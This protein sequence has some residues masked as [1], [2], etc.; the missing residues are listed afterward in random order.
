MSTARRWLAVGLA[1]GA[2]AL[3]LGLWLRAPAATVA[4]QLVRL[5][6]FFLHLQALA[7]A[8]TTVWVWSALRR[9]LG[10]GRRTLQALVAASAL[11]AGFTVAVAP[12]TNRI[13]YDEQIYQ[14]V[15]QSLA[16]RGRAEVCLEGS[17]E[18]GRLD[19]IRGQYNKQPYGYPYLVSWAFRL[20]GTHE[21]LA[22]VVNN[23]C[24]AALP[25][26]VWAL[27]SLLFD[28]AAA[29]W[30]AL[31]AALVPLVAVWSN[32]TAAEPSAMLF[33][34]LA[35]TAAT[36]Y[37]RHPGR[38]TLAWAVAALAFGVQFRPESAFLLPLALAFIVLLAPA[39]ARRAR[40]WLAGAIA[41]AL[42]ANLIAH[43]WA[44]Q[45]DSWGAAGGVRFSLAHVAH[46]LRTNG[47]FYFDNARFP[48]LYTLLALNGL[49]LRRGRAA[50][51]AALYFLV[52]WGVFL[53]FYAGS[54]DYGADVRFSLVS[55]PALLVLAGA[56]LAALVERGAR[57]WPAA[58]RRL[59]AGA[60]AVLAA[61]IATF[62]P[63]VRAVGEEAW[64][65]R[66]DVRFARQF[67]ARLPADAIV[68]SHD[69]TM[70]LVWGKGAAQTFI[71]AQEPDYVRGPLRARHSG[72]IYFHWNFWCNTNDPQQSAL[73][74]DVLARYRHRLV[75]ERHE[76]GARYA[77]Y[78]LFP[79][80]PPAAGAP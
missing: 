15:A 18:Y 60:L 10:G 72:R 31:L 14:Q 40:L 48:L 24:A 57:R 8:A 58:A 30:A 39:E 75:V 73:C 56:G 4:T 43:F 19:C 41:A 68:F 63:L 33:A 16:D 3:A 17:V 2:V 78:R 28:A 80:A 51:C 32:T 1:W 49:A 62:L 50:S 27:A 64:A 29:R 22:H 70:F 47:L 52:F 9:A 21:I 11:A 54:Y 53:S 12:R 44:V 38:S 55:A 34:A 13:F 71:A 69:P 36:A 37:A 20:G 67:A 6:P 23:L 79:A 77:L 59:A 5:Q 46:N 7:L 65:A 42:S 61:N 26:V 74:H 45:D 66:A 25:W 35:I 76:R